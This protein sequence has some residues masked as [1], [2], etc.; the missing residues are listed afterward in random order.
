[1]N[2]FCHNDQLCWRCARAYPG[3]GCEWADSF[4]P[5]KGWEAVPTEKAANVP[6]GGIIKSFRIRKC[7]KFLKEGQ[8]GG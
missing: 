1:M 2:K 8:K 4:K 3:N 5:V 6:G 7:P